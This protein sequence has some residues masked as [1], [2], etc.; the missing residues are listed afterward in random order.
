MKHTQ[1]ETTS[2][3]NEILQFMC[4]SGFPSSLDKCIFWPLLFSLLLVS[5]LLPHHNMKLKYRFNFFYA[6]FN[7]NY[8]PLLIFEKWLEYFIVLSFPQEKKTKL[9]C[10]LFACIDLF[11]YCSMSHS[12]VKTLNKSWH[13]FSMQGEKSFINTLKTS[14]NKN[15]IICKRIILNS[16]CWEVIFYTELEVKNYS[17]H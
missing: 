11:L 15:I 14:N 12:Q 10:L 3:E 17:P 1:T 6:L 2:Q 9:N 16:F 7:K 13:C 4:L 5:L 8:I